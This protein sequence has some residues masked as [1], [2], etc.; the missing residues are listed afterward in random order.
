[1]AVMRIE[2]CIIGVGK[3]ILDRLPRG[4]LVAEGTLEDNYEAALQEFKD[5][6]QP[7]F[8]EFEPPAGFRQRVLDHLRWYLESK[9]YL[10]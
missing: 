1:M 2:G 9:E 5:T 3:L 8:G 4:V 7:M 10:S 6:V